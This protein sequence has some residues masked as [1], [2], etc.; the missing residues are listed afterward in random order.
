MYW[1]DLSEVDLE[2]ASFT[3]CH[4]PTKADRPNG[5]IKLR[6]EDKPGRLQPA[7]DFYQRMKR[8]YK[9]E[10]NEYEASRWHIA[11]MEAQLK[12]LRADKN[13]K[14][15][16]CCLWYYKWSSGFGEAPLRACLWLLGLVFLPLAWTAA[17][18]VAQHFVWWSFDWGRIDAV[19]TAWLGYL[20]LTRSVPPGASGLLRAGMLFWQ[21]LVAI[22]AT[23]FVFALRNRFRR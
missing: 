1:L 23:L 12:L 4:W 15:L 6:D 20:P 10:H 3:T 8:K 7:R 13:S 14:F 5:R 9:D 11:E 2:N 17:A 18:E 19:V 16:K 22:Q 21:L